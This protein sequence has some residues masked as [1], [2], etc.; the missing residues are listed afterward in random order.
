MQHLFHFATY[1]VADQKKQKCFGRI[2]YFYGPK[3]LPPKIGGSVQ[4]NTSNMLQAG[5]GEHAAK[6][7]GA[8]YSKP[9]G[10]EPRQ[11]CVCAVSS[12]SGV[13]DTARPQCVW[14]TEPRKRISAW[15]LQ[16]PWRFVVEN[17]RV[18]NLKANFQAAEKIRGYILIL[19]VY[20]SLPIATASIPSLYSSN[21]WWQMLPC[22]LRHIY[23][24]CYL[25]PAAAKTIGLIHLHD[26][27][28]VEIESSA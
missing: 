17:R 12:L 3:R 20:T 10:N 22:M 8:G 27:D 15:L 14:D 13:R 19:E 2:A 23:L 4:S 1:C 18:L 9:A 24:F 6:A 7:T 25:F 21:I 28:D 5:P 11:L 26:S 16:M